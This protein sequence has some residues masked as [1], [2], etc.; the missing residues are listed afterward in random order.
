MKKN[1]LLHSLRDYIQKSGMISTGERV[2]VAV[3]GGIDSMVLLDVLHAIRSE[4]SL[5]LAIGHCNHQLRGNESD[6]DEAFVRA[7]AQ[8][9]GIECYIEQTSTEKIAD[10]EKKSLQETARELR[11]TFLQKLRSSSGFDVIATAHHADDNTET[12]LFNMFR[13]A[14]VQ[15]LSGIPAIRKDACIIRPLLFA[16]RDDIA[17]YA[18][19]QDIQFREDSSNANTEY[20]RNYL[21]HTLIPS[22]REHIN[23]NLTAT[24]QRTSELFNQLE[25]YIEE[26]SK[27]VVGTVV[28]AESKEEIILDLGKFHSLQIFMQ[29]YLLQQFAKRIAAGEIDFGSV[30]MLHR[31]S[32]GATG[33]FLTLANTVSV[34]KDRDRL[35]MTTIR[36]AGRYEHSIELNK[37]HEFTAFSFES[38]TVDHADV[39]G[40]PSV[41][42]IDS[43]FLGKNLVLRSWQEGDWFI[44]LGMSTKKKISDF[45]I[46][47]KVPVFEKNSIPLLVSDDQIVWVCGKRLDNRFK[48]TPDT[49]SI[50]KLEYLPRS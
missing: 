41:E 2:I 38:T 35:I 32:R 4:L 33:S 37:R 42:Y 5:T 23:P 30:K 3:S 9:Y 27:K 1:P 26:E 40:N 7:T 11:Y 14:G 21:R 17:S 15:G 18:K 50:T 34:Y 39:T 8:R 36:P 22:I 6:E 44:P 43:S 28:I 20:T 12:M 13:G 46:D 10:T 47:A 19:E 16:T 48:V 31:L 29:E 49:R 45:F 25:E 24:L